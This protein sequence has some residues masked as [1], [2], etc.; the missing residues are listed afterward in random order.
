MYVD[1]QDDPDILARYAWVLFELLMRIQRKT[2]F[3]SSLRKFD[4]IYVVINKEFRYMCCTLRAQACYLPSVQGLLVYI[5]VTRR[6][7]NDC[8]NASLYNVA[9]KKL[10]EERKA[11]VVALKDI[12]PGEEIFV[13]YGR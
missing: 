7:I 6:Y 13:D 12:K 1:A 11:L 10:P 4:P 8:R 3:L 9:F 5:D 2:I